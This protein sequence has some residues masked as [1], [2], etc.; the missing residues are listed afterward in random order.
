[1]KK[2]LAL[3]LCLFA[4]SSFGAVYQNYFTYSAS[5]GFTN[6]VYHNGAATFYP[7]LNAAVSAAAAGDYIWAAPQTHTISNALIVPV[8]ATLDLR[9]ATLNSYVAPLGTAGPTIIVRDNSRVLG[10]YVDL[11]LKGIASAGT[12]TYQAVIGSHK[13]I[14]TGTATNVWVYENS[15]ICETDAVFVRNTNVNRINFVS[16]NYTSRW[17]VLAFM[18]AAHTFNF[19]NCAMVTIGTNF[20]SGSGGRGNCLTSEAN[21]SGSKVTVSGGLMICSNSVG[22][23]VESFGGINY[24]LNNVGVTNLGTSVSFILTAGDVLVLDGTSVTSG[25][26]DDDFGSGVAIWRPGKYVGEFYGSITSGSATNAAGSR[27]AYLADVTASTNS[28]S[29]GFNLWGT[30]A[31]AGD[32]TFT[33]SNSRGA[34]NVY[35][36]PAYWAVTNGGAIVNAGKTPGM[37]HVLNNGVSTLI[38]SNTITTGSILSSGGVTN[39]AGSSEFRHN[40]FAPLVSVRQTTSNGRV[41]AIAITA[42][43]TSSTGGANLGALSYYMLENASSAVNYAGAV[44]AYW[45]DGSQ[46]SALVFNVVNGGADPSTRNDFTLKNVNATTADGF[47]SGAFTATNGFISP[48]TSDL[49]AIKT[50]QIQYPTNLTANIAAPDLTKMYGLISTN[51]NFAITGLSG[52]NTG[53]SDTNVQVCVRHYRNTSGSV[54]TITIPVSWTNVIGPQEYTLYFTNVGTLSIE[55]YPGL[56]TNYVFTSN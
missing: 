44:G 37:L 26:I 23:I 45:L 11:K 52:V 46:N 1:M 42:T 51:N 55:R 54:K 39:T 29:G 33:N 6:A 10:G 2:L 4:A 25:E 40:A 21:A 13:S 36:G 17:D 43:N 38:V 27:V 12:A 24:T 20:I 30:N 16:C 49:A 47:L 3:F 31:P 8:G 41:G 15:G 22:R 18:E 19:Y 28:I 9:G 7:T 50:G 32:G 53:A 56:A 34:S 48:G 5:P 35:V 14:N